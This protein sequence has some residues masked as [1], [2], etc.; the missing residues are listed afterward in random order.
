[1]TAYVTKAFGNNY[2]DIICFET[3]NDFI[4]FIQ[5]SG[6]VIVSKNDPA[7]THSLMADVKV[8]IYNNQA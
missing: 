4:E 5:N 6:T 8:V 7:V 2:E 1:M 3:L